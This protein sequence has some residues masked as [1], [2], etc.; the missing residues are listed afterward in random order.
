MGSSPTPT[1]L[2]KTIM[3][4]NGVKATDPIIP[5]GSVEICCCEVCLQETFRTCCVEHPEWLTPKSNKIAAKHIEDIGR[6]INENTPMVPCLVVESYDELSAPLKQTIC[7]KHL[8]QIVEKMNVK[9]WV[10]DSKL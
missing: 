8:Q 7:Q 6:Y 3:S 10:F 9:N 4:F 2:R 1:T 5:F